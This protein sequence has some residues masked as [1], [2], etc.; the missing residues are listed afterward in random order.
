M[1]NTQGQEDNINEM[2]HRIE[3][4]IAERSSRGTSKAALDEKEEMLD[5]RETELEE[6]ERA[7]REREAALATREEA[8]ARREALQTINPPPPPVPLVRGRGACEH[9]GV[10]VCSRTS[11]CF[12]EYGR[13]LHTHGCRACHV[14]WKKTGH[15]GGGRRRAAHSSWESR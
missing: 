6:R 10:G 2:L 1:S 9:C 12:D 11:A 8:V 13:D 14:A 4:M 3:T 5:D 7:V 15:K